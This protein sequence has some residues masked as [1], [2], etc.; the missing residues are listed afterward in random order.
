M[1]N[2]FMR[3]VLGALIAVMVVLVCVPAAFGA[4]GVGTVSQTELYNGT[5]KTFSHTVSGSDLMLIVAVTWEYHNDDDVSSV[6]WKYGEAS[7]EGLVYVGEVHTS[8]DARVEMW[9]KVNPSTG[10]YNIRVVFDATVD[11]DCVITAVTFTGVNT[12][13]PHRTFEGTAKQDDDGPAS[14]SF[15]TESGEL[16]FAAAS[17]E[18]RTFSNFVGDTE[19]WNIQS[20]NSHIS[21]AGGTILADASSETISWDISKSDHWAI[22]GIS[23]K[24]AAAGATTTLGDGTDPSNSTVA[25]GSTNQYLDQFTF[26]TN[27]GSDSVTALT[28]TTAN[29]TAIASV[30][31]WNN[32]LT[33]QYFSTD[34]TPNGNLWEFSGGT[35]IPVTTSSASFRVLFT[36]KSH[37]ALAAGTYAVTG[38]VTSYTC[39]N[40]QA[41]TDTDSATITVDNTP[42]A[43]ATWGTITPGDT[44]IELNWTNPGDGDFNKVV[45]LRRA[46]SAVGDTP[47]DG[48]EYNVNDTIGS[49]TVRYVCGKPGDLYRYRTYQWHGLLLQDLRL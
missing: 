45:I 17:V 31:I 44:Q 12:S 48:T 28:V 32:A 6:T 21:S 10:T 19:H 1:G 46:G 25:P 11:Q 37:A 30:E 29:T 47:T 16:V 40:A 33:T 5:A 22:G 36:A 27:S 42:P 35:A 15:T 49:S 13:D 41:G 34:S 7:P 38:T 3:R 8:D 26:V 14:H 43:D 9:K 4:V 23:I 20:A 24:P 2:G 18:S 39:T